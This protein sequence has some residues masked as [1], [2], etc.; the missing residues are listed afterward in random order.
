MLFGPYTTVL[1]AG[2]YRAY[3]RLKVPT[4]TIT[5]SLELLKLDVAGD[6]GS[7]LLGVRYVRGTDFRAGERY[8]E[9][10]VDFELLTAGIQS[11]FRVE[12]YGLSSLWL[13][14]VHVFSYPQAVFSHTSW[15]LPAREG[16]VTVTARFVDRAEN[17]SSGVPLTFTVTDTSPPEAWRD[18]GC[19]G[20]TC[21]VQVRDTIAGLNVDSAVYRYSIDGGMTWGDWIS[22]TCS[23]TDGSPHWETITAADI[24]LSIMA[25]EDTYL[26]FRVQDTAAAGNW[27]TSMPYKPLAWSIYLPLVLKP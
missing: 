25:S 18:F 15:T 24:P 5:R 9:I 3:F 13:D 17:V 4:A 23:G 16:V 2:Q 7:E 11:E 19:D 8:Q 6:G 20:L 1:P 21:T 26:Q 12:S 10:A 27:S 22:A 14:R